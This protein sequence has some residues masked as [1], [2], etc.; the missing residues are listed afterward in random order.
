ML[1]LFD[2]R[3][4]IAVQKL[5]APNVSGTEFHDFTACLPISGIFYEARIMTFSENLVYG[6]FFLV[7]LMLKLSSPWF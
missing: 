4:Q 1:L 5:S 6:I 3:N 7:F 2:G